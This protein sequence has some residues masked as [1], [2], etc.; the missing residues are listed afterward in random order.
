MLR[1]SSKA[2]M[3][4][5]S[6]VKGCLQAPTF[7]TLSVRVV[8]CS[9]PSGN[10]AFACRLLGELVL[11]ML[12]LSSDPDE[13]LWYSSSSSFRFLMRNSKF[14]SSGNLPSSSSPSE[15]ARSSSIRKPSGFHVKVLT[16]TLLGCAKNF[17]VDPSPAILS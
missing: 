10:T 12:L 3:V 15:S 14:V 16:S 11:D 8:L 13:M 6:S 17:V 7:E 2:H 5:K 9:F 4:E 1:N